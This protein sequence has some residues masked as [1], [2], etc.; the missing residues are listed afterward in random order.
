MFDGATS[1]RTVP[2]VKPLTILTAATA[3][4]AGFAL[5]VLF[6][7]ATWIHH[8]NAVRSPITP[9]VRACLLDTPGQL[10]HQCFPEG[11]PQ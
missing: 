5:V 10:H 2:G 3:A 11:A 4:T 8:Y 9:Q 6:F 7:A 1:A